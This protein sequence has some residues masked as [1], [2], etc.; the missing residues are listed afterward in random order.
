[1]S[2]APLSAKRAD[3][4]GATA[5]GK[6]LIAGSEQPTENSQDRFDRMPDPLQERMLCSAFPLIAVPI[7]IFRTPPFDP[8]R[9][10]VNAVDPKKGSDER[11]MKAVSQLAGVGIRVDTD[12]ITR[13][14][15][16]KAY[17]EQYIQ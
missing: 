9:R 4:Q 2:L 12:L 8:L 1:M 7:G 5:P 14:T 6:G 11:Y 10:L 15:P 17:D 3:R 16:E 13:L